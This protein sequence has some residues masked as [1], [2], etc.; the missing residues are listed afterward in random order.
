MI[1]F[2]SLYID[3]CVCMCVYTHEHIY[4]KKFNSYIYTVIDIFQYNSTW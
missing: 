3:V 4:M 1:S 2:L